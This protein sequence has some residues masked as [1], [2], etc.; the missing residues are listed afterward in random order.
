L[1]KKEILIIGSRGSEL[2]L[3]Q[4]NFIKSEIEKKN[5]NITVEVKLI[6]T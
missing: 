2:A 6:K 1:A 4:T 5:K 3:W